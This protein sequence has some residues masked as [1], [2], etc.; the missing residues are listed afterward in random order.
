MSRLTVRHRPSS[1]RPLAGILAVALALGA[2]VGT[3][4]V[5]LAASS[6]S[7]AVQSLVERIVSGATDD[8]SGVVCPELEDEILAELDPSAS[9]VSTGGMAITITDPVVTVVSEDDESAVVNLTGTMRISFDEEQAR[10][11]A[12]AQLEAQGEEAT[13]VAVDAMLAFMTAF[14]SE[15]LPIDEDLA[16]VQRDSGWV[17]CETGDSDSADG[18]FSGAGMCGLVALDELAPFSPMAISSS[19]GEGDFCQWIGADDEGYFSIDV[20]FLRDAR[21]DDY[22]AMDPAAQELTVGGQPAIGSAGQLYIEVDGGV[23][24]VLPYLIDGPEPD[25]DPIAVATSVAELFLPR[26]GQLPASA[27]VDPGPGP[28][29]S[30][31][32]ADCAVIDLEALNALS[33]LRNDSVSGSDGACTFISNDMEAGAPFLSVTL[34]PTL[35]IEDLGIVFPDGTEGDLDGH[36]SFGAVDMLWVELDE[37]LLTIMPVYAA[38]PEAANVDADTYA[39]DVARLVIGAI[40]DQG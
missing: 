12:R 15:D 10:E 14:A 32:L 6:P 3:S 22:R 9:G 24:S 21:L 36:R 33:P 39:A 27:P 38:S 5:A 26:L 25:A 40:A 1:P 20:G 13:D 37:G 29:G 30:G 31:A 8:L 35:R 11:L 23:L 34:D 28:N 19:T 18:A 7:E 17:V 4:A 16:V 2:V